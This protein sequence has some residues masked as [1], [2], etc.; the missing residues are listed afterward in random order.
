MCGLTSQRDVWQE[1]TK[2]LINCM[3]LCESWGGGKH[4]DFVHLYILMAP[5]GNL[6]PEVTF[7]SDAKK[8]ADQNILFS[9]GVES[10]LVL[11]YVFTIPF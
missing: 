1:V 10:I 8:Y 4:F 2:I 7:S 11:L 3:K 5:P 9:C 6:L